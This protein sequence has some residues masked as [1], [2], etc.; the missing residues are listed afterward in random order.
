M[1]EMTRGQLLEPQFPGAYHKLMTTAGMEPRVY[2]TVAHLGATLE[3]KLAQA[4]EE[5]QKLIESWAELKEENGQ[6]FWKVPDERATEWAEANKLFHEEKIQIEEP[7]LAL[8]EVRTAP[9]TPADYLVL[10]P[11]FNADASKG[12]KLVEEENGK[13]QDH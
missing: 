1:I 5:H 11:I 7:K 2:T 9:L 10:K 3:Y 4:R 8:T 6:K 13:N 12:L